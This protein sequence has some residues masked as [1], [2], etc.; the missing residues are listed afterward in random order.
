MKRLHAKP[1]SLYNREGL[2]VPPFRTD[3][4]RLVSEK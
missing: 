4:F 3:S 1:M 2:P